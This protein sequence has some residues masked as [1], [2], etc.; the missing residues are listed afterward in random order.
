VSEDRGKLRISNADRDQA[1]ARLQQSL[2][3]GRIDLVEF[4]ERTMAVYE[5]KT[6]AELDLIFED[7]PADPSGGLA[8]PGNAPA[9]AE[10]EG[11]AQRIR[12]GV[13]SAFHPL[14]VVGC[15]TVTIWLIS[16]I[17][18]GEIQNFWPAWPLGILTAI[19]I[20]TWLTGDDDDDDEDEDG[21]KDDGASKS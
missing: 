14:I 11:V 7:L 13:P 10:P 21:D 5:A 19:G 20:A 8:V 18:S 12:R 3:E 15:I 4:D 16:S 17:S 6:Q 9:P 2:D 1:V